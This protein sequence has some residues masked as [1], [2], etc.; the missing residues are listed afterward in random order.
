[1][2]ST[3]LLLSAMVVVFLLAGTSTAQGVGGH[4]EIYYDEESG[5]MAALCSTTVDYD[6]A[7]WYEAKVSCRSLTRTG[8][9]SR[10]A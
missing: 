4:S 7:L 10:I 9:F 3:E 8:A 6:T 2:K 5:K 1:M